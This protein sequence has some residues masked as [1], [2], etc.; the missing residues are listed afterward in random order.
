MARKEWEKDLPL[1]V[2]DI[3]SENRDS[4][5]SKCLKELKGEGIDIVTPITDIRGIAK[6]YSKRFKVPIKVSEEAFRDHPYADAMHRYKKGKS[7]IYLHPLLQ[8]Y[9]EKYVVGTIEHEI[10]HMKVE[11][12]WEEAL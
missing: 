11:R 4:T 7:T 6:K 1:G 3:L 12:K 10:D 2:A 5:T 9:P 8:Y